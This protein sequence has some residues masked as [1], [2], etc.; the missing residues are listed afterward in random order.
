MASLEQIEAVRSGQIDAGFIYNM[1]QTDP[2]LDQVQ[3]GRHGIALAVPKSH[4]L[5]KA[6]KV[7]LRD[8]VDVPFILFPRRESPAVYDRLMHECYRGGVKL[9]R[10]VSQA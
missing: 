9:L 6:R 4:P 8:L 1:T 7:R 5:S 2:E 10:V 3:V